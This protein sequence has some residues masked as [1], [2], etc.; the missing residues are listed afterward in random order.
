MTWI[1]NT[2]A[3]VTLP[4]KEKASEG[5]MRWVWSVHPCTHAHA[6]PCVLTIAPIYGQI[7]HAKGGRVNTC[8]GFI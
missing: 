8:R 6:H 4:N 5:E 3:F 1:N 2:S 7:D